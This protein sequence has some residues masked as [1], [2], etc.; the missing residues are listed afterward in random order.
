MA[1][2]G[3]NAFEVRPAR[4]GWVVRHGEFERW[5]RTQFEAELS[6]RNAAR[7]EHV[8]FVLKDDCGGVSAISTYGDE[9]YA[10]VDDT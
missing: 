4:D 1:G 3:R 9:R 8:E 7:S 6:A 2:D 5:Y 10:R